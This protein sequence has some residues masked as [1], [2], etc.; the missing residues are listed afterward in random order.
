MRRATEE[1]YHRTIQR[2]VSAVFQHLDE[3]ITV[4]G[5]ADYVGYSRFHFGRL[6]YRFMHE[7]VS[8][9]V[10]RI[11]LERAA[12]SIRNTDDALG[13]IALDAGYGSPEAF[14]RAF[15]SRFDI[16]PSLFRDQEEAQVW[17]KSPNGVHWNVD[18]VW[19][20]SLLVAFRKQTQGTM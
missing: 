4:N 1:Q 19:K 17:L 10:I 7:S 12:W 14:A 3:Q 5:L 20:S 13:R 6:F 9:F 11:R 16:L 18:G 8:E 15:R 2:F